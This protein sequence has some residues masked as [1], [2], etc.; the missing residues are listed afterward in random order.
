[1]KVSHR[2]LIAAGLLAAA[3]AALPAGAAAQETT[4]K[5]GVAVSR[6]QAEQPTYWDDRLTTTFFGIQTRLRF[7]PIAVQ[8]ELLV[9]TK[10]ANASQAPEEEQVRL[11]YLELPVLLVLPFRVGRA[12]PFIY[13]GP[14]VMLESRCRW[15]YRE[16]GLRSNVGCDPPREQLFRRN[17]LD[18]GAVVGGGAAHPLGPG[19]V[20]LEARHSW[21]LRNIHRDPGQE[22][23]NRTFYVMLGYSLSWEPGG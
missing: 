16:Q 6:L 19:R 1:M 14:S 8:P 18:Y 11:E 22:L 12:E 10:G 20:S 5:A 21:G 7:G 15:F 13:G 9:V 23:R 2:W 17:A 3:Q 4:L